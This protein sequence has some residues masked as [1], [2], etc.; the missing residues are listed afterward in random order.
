MP[1]GTL[2][3]GA[4]DV[5]RLLDAPAG[6]YVH[7][8]FCSSI[9]PFCP[10]DK[11]RLGDVP[12]MPYLEALRRE[13]D[14]VVDAHTARFGSFTSLYVG[15][16]TPTLFPEVLAD[17]V[18]RV[19]TA[20]R[21]AVEVLPTHA[22]PARLDALAAA[23]FDAVSIGAQSFHDPVLRRLGRP[24]DADAS[25][26]A[27]L[28]AVGRFAVVDV[29][30]IVDVALPGSSPAA[31]T[32]VRAFL[33]DVAWCFETGA[34]Q[35]STYPLMRFG[36]TP[37]GVARHARRREHAVLSQ[38]AELARRL[39][40]ERRSVWT[41]NRLGSP[42]YTSITRRRFLGMGAGASSVTGRDL[43]VNHFGL[44][45]YEAAVAAGRVPVARRFHLGALGGAAYE[46]FWQAYAGAVDP[47]TLTAAYGLVGAG[48]V[49][50]LT[51]VGRAA[52]LVRSDDG[53]LRLTPRGYDVFHDLERAV[54]YGLIEPL[55][56][57]MLREHGDVAMQPTA[58]W[59][60]PARGRSGPVWWLAR[61]LTERRVL[62]GA[63]PAER[64]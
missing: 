35:V 31:A 51:A 52:G 39:G 62:D 40:Y 17:L 6:A 9:C 48:P 36:Y 22:T 13:V 27:V 32:A 34:D 30:L 55:W 47:A 26:R 38:V 23:G 54:T 7:V 33:D 12:A 53:L 43:L 41:F 42:P 28:A 63:R 20:G 16:G 2:L 21:R 44:A 8:P 45:A 58:G 11:V 37:F 19:P 1:V 59:A 50:G 64:S 24:H 49:R 4:A 15:G 56:A 61:T 57:Q 25:R 14:A 29:D 18:E 60:R 46:A 10:Y 5:V 3:A